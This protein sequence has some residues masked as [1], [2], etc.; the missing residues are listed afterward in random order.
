VWKS[1][2][3]FAR[4]EWKTASKNSENGQLSACA[5][6]FVAVA[7]FNADGQTIPA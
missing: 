3:V 7:G 6:P 4:K 5:I 2:K 1:H